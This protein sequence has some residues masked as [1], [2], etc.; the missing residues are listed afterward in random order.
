[1]IILGIETSC[2]ETSAALLEIKQG[3]FNV[4]SNTVSS[5]KKIQAKY[6][7]IVP[8]IAARKQIEDMI[9]VLE[10]TLKNT[11]KKNI[12]AIA[13]TVGPGLAT[14]LQVGIDTAK[15]LVYAW[16][17]PIIPINHLEG[18]LYSPLL[19]KKNKI[20]F[21]AIG[22]VVSGGHTELILV[23]DY[24][25]YESLGRTRDDAAGEAFDKVAKLLGLG[26]PGG[27]IISKLAAKGDSGKYNFPRGMIDST[28]YDFSFS[29]LKT[30]VLYFL[31]DRQLSIVK[32]QM[33]NNICASFQQAVVD[34]L[35]TKAVRA[36]QAHKA[37]S[38]LVG[39][40]VIANPLLRQT[41]EKACAGINTDCL[42][43]PLSY[44][45]DNAA[46]IA[47]AGYF[48]Y[49]TGD[50]IKPDPQSKAWQ[51]ISAQPNLRL[52]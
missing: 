33:S 50:F 12:D 21:P 39:G 31:R 44:T 11:D 36:I 3:K 14:S 34:V 9:P 16:Q 48:R 42:I 20:K 32:G 27:P 1:M 52:I 8:E 22:L 49:K 38:L 29:G 15:T 28:D 35:V 45:G 10:Q 40:G 23:K 41:L 19:E 51:Q 18:H 47:L 4:L 2:D 46:M 25:K 24:L 26:Y 43:S 5:S 37:K 17:K 30:A 6:G 13:A 7:G